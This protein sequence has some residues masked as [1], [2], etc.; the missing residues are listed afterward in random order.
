MRL[1]QAIFREAITKFKGWLTAFLIIDH[2]IH[3]EF[4]TTWPLRV[5]RICAVADK[6][7][8]DLIGHGVNS[9]FC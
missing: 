4:R 1:G 3:G 6:I 7:S 5:R 2:E 8:R 9:L